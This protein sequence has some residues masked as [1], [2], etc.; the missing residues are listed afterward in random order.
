VAYGTYLSLMDRRRGFAEPTRD[1]LI[2]EAWAR[3]HHGQ[4][5]TAKRMFERLH[6]VYATKETREG[7]E[8]VGNDL[9]HFGL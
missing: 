2:Q 3:Y 7:L 6:R 1:Q 9:D 5:H 4:K 8:V